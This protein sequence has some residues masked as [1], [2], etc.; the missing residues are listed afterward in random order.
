[1]E[2]I[3]SGCQLP[4][5]S[6]PSSSSQPSSDGCGPS[7]DRYLYADTATHLTSYAARAIDLNRTLPAMMNAGVFAPAGGAGVGDGSSGVSVSVLIAEDARGNVTLGGG[8]GT[9]EVKALPADSL[10]RG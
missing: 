5:G 3:A 1:M 4:K 10:F 9:D 7:Y 2:A 6:P 8:T